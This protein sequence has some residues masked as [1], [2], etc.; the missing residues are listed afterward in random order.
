MHAN[1]IHDSSLFAHRSPLVRVPCQPIVGLTCVAN[2]Q[3]MKVFASVRPDGSGD[4]PH[5]AM[6][7]DQKFGS[8]PPSAGLEQRLVVPEVVHSLPD[9]IGAELNGDVPKPTHTPR[10]IA[11]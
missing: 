9:H 10:V 7:P 1:L 3:G 6:S 4:T 8:R 5:H 2:L 11:A